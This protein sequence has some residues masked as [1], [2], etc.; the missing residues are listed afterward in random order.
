MGALMRVLMALAGL[1]FIAPSW[2]A[3]LVA[4][5]V[6]APAILSQIV[7]RRG[8]GGGDAA[9]TRMGATR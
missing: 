6:A 4:L 8:G 3:D 1:I 5:A 2:Q 7:A 9:L